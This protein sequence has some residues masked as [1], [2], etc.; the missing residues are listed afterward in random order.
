MFLAFL[1]D[2]GCELGDFWKK[3]DICCP[4]KR[5][6]LSHWGREEH[7]FPATNHH[8]YS[9]T[10]NPEK[11]QEDSEDHYKLCSD[12]YLYCL[13][14]SREVI[15]VLLFMYG[16]GRSPDL[17]NAE[18][19]SGWAGVHLKSLNSQSQIVFLHLSLLPFYVLNK[20]LEFLKPLNRNGH[21]HP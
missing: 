7:F 16:S 20:S 12:F 11:C 8:S 2:W 5:G 9:S 3:S 6:E 14:W 21:G 13:D 19:E 15:L 17:P 4:L 10:M 1:H 18:V